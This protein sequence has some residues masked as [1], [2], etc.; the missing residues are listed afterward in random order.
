MIS[1]GE[2]EQDRATGFGIGKAFA[3]RIL[4]GATTFF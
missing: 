3:F 2:T 1:N 4:S